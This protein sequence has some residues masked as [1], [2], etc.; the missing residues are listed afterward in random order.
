MMTSEKKTEQN[1][2]S[3]EKQGPPVPMASRVAATGFFGGVLWSFIAY[4][5]YLFHFS[6]VSPNMILQPFVLG[7]W[8]KHGLGTVIS[9]IL[10]GIL[11]IGAAFLYFLLLKRLKTMWPGILYGFLLWML[12]FFV[13]NPIFPDVRAVIELKADTVITTICIY[14]LYGLFVGYSI[15]FEYNELNS[16]KLARA[17]G[18]VHRE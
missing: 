17:L 9:I 1:E 2:Q 5:A 3:Y 7:E 16:E 12:V 18:T 14:L 6:E 4:I 13:F 11:S 8:K 15:S 10:I